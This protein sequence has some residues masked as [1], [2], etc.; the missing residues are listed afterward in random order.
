[1]DTNLHL[2]AGLGNPGEKYART[3]HNVGFMALERL[4]KLWSAQW[5]FEK[6][7]C[8]NVAKAQVEGRKALLCCP[9]T[10]MNSSGRAVGALVNYYHISLEN[11]L[12]VSDDADLPLGWIRLRPGGG[13]GG[14]HGLE[15]IEQA[16]GTQNYARLRIGIGRRN[17]L[18]EITNYVL[19]EFS[20][21]EQSILDLVLDRAVR[22]INCWLLDGIEK[23]MN[24]Y[25]GQVEPEKDKEQQK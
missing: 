14:H 2:I 23:A 9:Q 4:A 11:L 1:M 17:G 6:A 21:Q 25:N 18:R 16:L 22:Q 5:V 15:S 10:Y 7:F 12:I 8:A 24:K 13:N 20:P 3:R 19:G